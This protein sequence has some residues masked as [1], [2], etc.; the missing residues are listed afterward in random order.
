MILVNIFKITSPRHNLLHWDEPKDGRSPCP[1]WSWSIFWA[2]DS[3]EMIHCSSA[4]SFWSFHGKLKF[5]VQLHAERLFRILW[6]S[7]E[8]SCLGLDCGVPNKK[9]ALARARRTQKF[10][11]RTMLAWYL[12]VSGRLQKM[13][14]CPQITMSTARSEIIPPAGAGL[15][16][17]HQN[18]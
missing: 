16:T 17:W 11:L 8:D 3:N 10:P 15:N 1:F 9:W 4:S 5:S 7:S 6:K 18:H 14:M 2:V 12:S 13:R